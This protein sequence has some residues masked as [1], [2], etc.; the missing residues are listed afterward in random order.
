LSEEGDMLS[1]WRAY[2]E[3]GAGMS[4]GFDSAAFYEERAQQ[5]RPELPPLGKVIYDV[6]TQQ[7]IIAPNMVQI[8]EFFKSHAAPKLDRL[9]QF[10]ESGPNLAEDG[11]P[12]MPN[13]VTMQ[14]M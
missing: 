1:Q 13:E 3:N 9:F 11:Q 10:F 6:A 14:Q 8:S 7:Q 12:E 2:S 4:I 5:T